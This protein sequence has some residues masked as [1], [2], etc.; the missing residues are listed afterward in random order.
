MA[1]WLM[2][3]MGFAPVGSLVA[4]ALAAAYG[5]CAVMAGG[6]VLCALGGIAFARW[7]W[8]RPV[9]RGSSSG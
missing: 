2:I 4:G 9:G 5:P 7:S 6:G 1:I 3:F 8:T